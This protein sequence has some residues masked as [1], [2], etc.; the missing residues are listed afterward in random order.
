M[1]DQ[2]N[3][4]QLPTFTETRL[5][6][7]TLTDTF[8]RGTERTIYCM[9]L[10][11]SVQEALERSRVEYGPWVVLNAW[12]SRRLP[13]ESTIIGGGFFLKGER[14]A[15]HPHCLKNIRQAKGIYPRRRSS[16]KAK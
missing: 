4:L 2:M 15:Q 14:D 13:L 16:Q 10:A 6:S 11:N 9:T 3:T 8:K 12:G 1:R 5:V 7:L